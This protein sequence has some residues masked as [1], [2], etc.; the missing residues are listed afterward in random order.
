MKEN[1]IDEIMRWYDNFTEIVK[2]LSMS[3]EE[4]IRKLK[5][6]VVTDEIASDFSEI[7]MLYAQ[8]LLS[9][10]WITQEQFKLAQDIEEKLEQMTQKKELWNDD[11]LLNSAE[12]N[13]C[14]KRGMEL[15]QTLET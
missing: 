12:W 15:M 5:G 10:G 6:T 2:Q 1:D 4:Q 7:G 14:R 11:A 8:K 3:A 9:Y 13:N